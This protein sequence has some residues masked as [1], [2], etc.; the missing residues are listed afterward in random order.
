[1]PLYLNDHKRN[2]GTAFSALQDGNRAWWTNNVMSY[3]WR[4]EVRAA[5]LSPAWFDDIDRRFIHA[6]RLFAH[7]SRVF[8]RVIPFDRLAN[9]RILEIGC[10]MGLHTELMARAG[11]HVTAIDISPRSVEATRARLT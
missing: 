3:D 8:D 4:H 11:G 7:G 9:R 2:G 5:E 1:M 10:G 6:S